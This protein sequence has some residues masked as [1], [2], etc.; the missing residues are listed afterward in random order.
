MQLKTAGTKG[1]LVEVVSS[2]FAR[3][4]ELL[5]ADARYRQSSF[6]GSTIHVVVDDAETAPPEIKRILESGNITVST[7]NRIPFTMEDVFMSLVE[8]QELSLASQSS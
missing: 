6:F 8:E 7:I 2:D 1:E 5:S 4:L 3:T